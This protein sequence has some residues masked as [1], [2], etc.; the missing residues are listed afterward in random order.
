M[1]TSSTPWEASIRSVFP[2]AATTIP[3][4]LPVVGPGTRAAPMTRGTR[5]ERSQTAF[6]V[7]AA[8]GP[9]SSR[10]HSHEALGGATQRRG[11]TW[12]HYQ[13]MK[14]DW[15][16]GGPRGWIRRGDGRHGAHSAGRSSSSGT[17][18]PSKMATCTACALSMIAPR[19]SFG[20]TWTRL[21][22]EPRRSARCSTASRK[23]ALVR[24]Q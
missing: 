23:S 12:P 24:S 11:R 10:G 21:R 15:I 5:S 16:V 7:A 18:T 19:S 20:P 3:Q 6:S 4:C 2:V 8:E 14:L 13:V 9:V 22:F 17:V 1:G